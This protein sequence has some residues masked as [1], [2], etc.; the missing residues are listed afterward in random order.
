MLAPI[1]ILSAVLLGAVL[2]F[3]GCSE[4]DEGLSCDECMKVKNET[5]GTSTT[6]TEATASNNAGYDPV[7]FAT[8]DTME[9]EFLIFAAENITDD[10]A[11][12][13]IFGTVYAVVLPV[14]TDTKGTYTADDGAELFY[15]ENYD[16]AT[17][18]GAMTT[19]YSGST[20]VTVK[21]TKAG[22]VGTVYE[23]KFEG[24]LS[25]FLGAGDD[26]VLSGEF[27]TERE[28]DDF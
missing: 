1:R 23:G 27:K 11:S 7:V 16:T 13:I 26:I 19:G 2:I 22:G 20:N 8:N 3:A 28:A 15:G 17:D 4:E 14:G 21:L 12:D 25:D 24:T 9:P 6:L 5:A 18:G 10:G